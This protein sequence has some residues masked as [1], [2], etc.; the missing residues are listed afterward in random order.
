MW[1][2]EC[3]KVFVTETPQIERTVQQVIESA[4]YRN[5]MLSEVSLL[6]F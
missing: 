6:L 1:T 4:N 3:F 2:Y 5:F